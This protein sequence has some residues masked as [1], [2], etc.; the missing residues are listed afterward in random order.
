MP[1]APQVTVQTIPSLRVLEIRRPIASHAEA[2]ALLSG[3]REA[4]GDA[5]QGPGIC[6]TFGRTPEGRIDAQMA[7]P[8]D[9]A[10]VV[11]DLPEVEGA[12]LSTL[13][14]DIFLHIEHSGPYVADGNQDGIP[15]T[16][17]RLGQFARENRLLI[18]D[19]PSR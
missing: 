8:V 10:V 11:L 7:I 16:I 4:A 3:L 13:P 17:G 1:N 6:V 14:A 19:N 15:E 9:E 12:S 18:G 5:A 2:A